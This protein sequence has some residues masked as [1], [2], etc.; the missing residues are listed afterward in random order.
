MD[1]LNTFLA[2][3]Q[4]LLEM[5]L[6]D[7]PPIITY[8][9]QITSRSKCFTMILTS[10]IK[11]GERDISV[12]VKIDDK[13]VGMALGIKLKNPYTLTGSCPGIEIRL[14]NKIMLFI[15]F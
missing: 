3:L 14:A 11:D 13:T 1:F 15:S 6:H 5:T 2:D 10:P 8:P 12:T 7:A 9:D 4:E